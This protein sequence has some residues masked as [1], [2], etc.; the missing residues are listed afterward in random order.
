MVPRRYFAVPALL[1]SPTP[2]Q[3]PPALCHKKGGKRG[4]LVMSVSTLRWRSSRPA[5]AAERLSSSLETAP[6]LALPPRPRPRRDDMMMMMGTVCGL[7]RYCTLRLV[8]G[9]IVGAFMACRLLSSKID[10]I[11]A[12]AVAQRRFAMRALGD[13]WTCNMQQLMRPHFSRCCESTVSL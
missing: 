7:L 9:A 4:G 8:S 3:Y 6:P 13:G 1:V 5:S 10:Y 12:R 2:S 11:D